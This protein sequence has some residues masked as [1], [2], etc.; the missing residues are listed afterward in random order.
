M[1]DETSQ[2]DVWEADSR[3]GDS[4]RVVIDARGVAVSVRFVDGARG[5]GVCAHEDAEAMFGAELDAV[6]SPEARAEMADRL[7]VYGVWA[8]RRDDLIP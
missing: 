8:T 4:Y 3:D 1:Y 5:G 6:F 2:G 7:R